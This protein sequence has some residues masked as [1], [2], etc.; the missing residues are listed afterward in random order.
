MKKEKEIRNLAEYLKTEYP[1]GLSLHRI[2][3][4]EALEWVLGESDEK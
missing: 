4:I 3:F 2:G 1:M